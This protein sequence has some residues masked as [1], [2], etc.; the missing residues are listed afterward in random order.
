LKAGGKEG[1][2]NIVNPVGGKFDL[3][4]AEGLNKFYKEAAKVITKFKLPR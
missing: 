1:L 2:I 3:N 4:S